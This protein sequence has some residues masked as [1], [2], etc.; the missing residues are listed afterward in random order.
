MPIL[1]QVYN[2]SPLART[3]L[4]NLI[5]LGILP[6]RP[7]LLETFLSPLDDELATLGYGVRTYD[8]VDKVLFD[9]RA[10]LIQKHGDIV[11]IEKMLG[12]RGHNA[13]CPCRSCKM[14]GVQDVSGKGKIY[15][16]PLVTPNVEHLTRPSV[17]PRNL[18]R[19]THGEFEDVLQRMTAATTKKEKDE[20]GKAFGI[21][22]GAVLSRVHSVDLARSVPW[23]WV[24][25]F[26]ENV[27]PNLADLWTG[28][29]KGLD[30]GTED[31]E[32]A[33]HVWEE[34]GEETANAVK[35]IPAAFVR[36]LSNIADDR[37]HFMAESWG[38]WFMYIAPI[39][40]RGRFQK[41]CYYKHM[42]SLANIM[43]MTLKF[44]ITD[45]EVDELEEMIVQ[46]VKLYEQFVSLLAFSFHTYAN[47]L[48]ILLSIR[49][50]KTFNVYSYDPWSLTYC[51]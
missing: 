47:L 25:L 17:D 48:Q 5:C 2:H 27:C 3:H 24:H 35:T 41:N 21:Q 42:C 19:R 12:I 36:V 30:T 43:K 11:A 26:C 28:R 22:Q 38:F 31:Y 34:I 39:V 33:P 9:L 7:K 23:D 40:L 8:A 10:Y 16:I 50:T 20:I 46:W 18:P 14:K 13:Y 15:Y 45:Q 49:R 1:L 51:R 29:F 37:S 4:E 44:E 32:L 6:K